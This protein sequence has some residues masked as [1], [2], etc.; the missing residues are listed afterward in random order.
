MT[1]STK[2][3]LEAIKISYP[4]LLRYQNMGILHSPGNRWGWEYRYTKVEFKKIVAKME[5]MVENPKKYRHLN[6]KIK[7]LSAFKKDLLPINSSLV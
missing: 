2:D 5:D 3:L 1:Y 7:R 6:V 4:T